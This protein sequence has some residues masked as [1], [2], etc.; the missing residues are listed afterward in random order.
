MKYFIIGLLVTVMTYSLASAQKLMGLVVEKDK[1][2]KDQPLP[3]ANVHWLGTMQAT[4]TRQN[5]IFLI[6]RNSDTNRLVISF[7]G[8]G[9]D[10]IDVKDQNNVKVE[11]H[12]AT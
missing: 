4:T 5:G 10:T 2:G 12:S 1:Q 7:V 6:D 11:L 3:G 8:Y 9:S